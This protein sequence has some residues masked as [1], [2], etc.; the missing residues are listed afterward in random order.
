MEELAKC[1]NIILF[2]QLMEG[3]NDDDVVCETATPDQNLCLITNNKLDCNSI[4]LECNHQFNY[5]PL[6]NEVVY[7]KTKKLLDNSKLKVN[8]MKCPYC[9]SI[10]NRLLP[11]YKYYSV[12]SIRGVTFPEEHC[13]KIHK[14]EHEII[15]GGKMCGVTACVTV[16]GIFCNKHMKASKKDREILDSEPSTT[17]ELYNKLKIDDLKAL[18]KLNNCLVGGKKQELINRIIVNNKSNKNWKDK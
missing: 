1:N 15:K 18:L 12:K 6:Y 16:D 8:E 3:D 9:R 14:C 10:T 4:K 5:E 13:L 2:K 7:Q 17:Y 11:C